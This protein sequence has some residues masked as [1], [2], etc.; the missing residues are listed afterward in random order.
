[1]HLENGENPLQQTEYTKDQYTLI[2]KTYLFKAALWNITMFK[3]N[4]K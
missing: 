3:M 1:M 2:W 4:K